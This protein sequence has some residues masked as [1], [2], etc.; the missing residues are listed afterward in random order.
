MRL[1]SNGWTGTRIGTR[2]TRRTH[3]DHLLVFRLIGNDLIEPVE[4]YLARQ[5]PQ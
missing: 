5:P 4:S 3:P 1:D 2:G